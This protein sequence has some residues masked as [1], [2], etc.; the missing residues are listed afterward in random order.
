MI[1]YT[2]KPPSGL[3]SFVFALF[4]SIFRYQHTSFSVTL[5]CV[6]TLAISSIFYSQL[7]RSR[8]S[9]LSLGLKV[10]AR[11]NGVNLLWAFITIGLTLF[12]YRTAYVFM[13]PLLITLLSSATTAFLKAQNSSKL[14]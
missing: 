10:Q 14:I 11:I 5:Y 1:K 4:Y 8:E 7:T 12:G 13:I 9:A 6:P 3:S 2:P